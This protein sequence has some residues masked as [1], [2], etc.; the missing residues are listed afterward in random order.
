MLLCGCALPLGGKLA[1][2]SPPGGRSL[3]WAACAA[4]L[5]SLP[6]VK[7][8]ALGLLSLPACVWL[9]YRAQGRAAVCWCTVTTLCASLLTGGAASALAARGVGPWAGVGWSLALEG[10]FYLLVQLLP[11]VMKEVRQVELRVGERSIMLPAMV[12][13]GNL[14][15]DPITAL[16]VL[17]IPLRAA[18]A[19][20]PEAGVIDPLH[21]LPQGFRLLHVRTAAGS[22]LLPMFRPDRCWLYLDGQ[23]QET[24]LLAAVVGREYRGTQALVPLCAIRE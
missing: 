6:A 5:L 11:C 16:P 23:R 4:G 13:S 15:R 14:M 22:G 19:L 20:Y 10:F 17:V 2:V 21:V 9:A 12:D 18:H 24:R 1:G 3:L 7:L 8:P